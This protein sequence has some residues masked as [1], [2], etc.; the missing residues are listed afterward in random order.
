MHHFIDRFKVLRIF[1]RV[2][3]IQIFDDFL[4]LLDLTT[5]VAAVGDLKWSVIPMIVVSCL[6]MI[7]LSLI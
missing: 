5:L 3:V 2:D 4:E 7:R 1:Y 6:N